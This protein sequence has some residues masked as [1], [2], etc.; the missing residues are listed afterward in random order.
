[1]QTAGGHALLESFHHQV[2]R[3]VESQIAQ[4]V[5]ELSQ[6]LLDR[7]M[8]ENDRD[9]ALQ[10]FK[11]H[12]YLEN[13]R[14]QI[15]DRFCQLLQ[16]ALSGDDSSI[17]VIPH[18]RPSAELA[19]LLEAAE[20]DADLYTQCTSLREEVFTTLFQRALNLL[21]PEPAAR[22]VAREVFQ[23]E[24]AANLG[25]LYVSL[26]QLIESPDQTRGTI[27]RRTNILAWIS[28]LEKK[29]R[30]P[31][32]DSSTRS[33]TQE[34]LEELHNRLDHLDNLSQ[35]AKRLRERWFHP[36]DE[37]QHKQYT[38]EELLDEVQKLFH[39]LATLEGVPRSLRALAARI[40]PIV[41]SVA[42]TDRASFM[43]ALH[44]ARQ[45]LHQVTATVMHWLESSPDERRKMLLNVRQ[46][47]DAGVLAG[48]ASYQGDPALM[49]AL[50]QELI[51]Y[52]AYQMQRVERDASESLSHRNPA[53]DYLDEINTKL[54]EKLQDVVELPPLLHKLVF[55]LWNRVIAETWL[56]HG[57]DAIATQ[58]ALSLVDDI[59]WYLHCDD[60]Q[61]EY[62]NTEFLGEQIERDLLH[63]L[64]SIDFNRA[65]GIEL[66]SSLKRL[67]RRLHE[68]KKPTAKSAS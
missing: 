51:D 23:A 31:A 62:T 24:F 22:D 34:R 46:S 66:I 15:C 14:Q 60:S 63:G 1:M 56:E 19:A 44:P 52:F 47:I 12:K 61:L 9:A 30:N 58:Q 54:E 35:A 26:L 65:K 50:H 29:L 41:E 6:K 28:H 49:R 45:L 43:Q 5:A 68:D 40:R 67:R 55:G 57:E 13:S 8:S 18:Q 10:F 16:K 39:P 20:T 3:W 17:R 53:I 42:L 33:M 37:L 2:G 38:D 27:D 21:D 11:H 4:C 59:I 36:H 48:N 25:M 32:I 7:A 64:K